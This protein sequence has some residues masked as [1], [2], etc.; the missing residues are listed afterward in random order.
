MSLKH[1]Q[2]H[3]P[4]LYSRF[5]AEG[6]RIR[7]KMAKT[8]SSIWSTWEGCCWWTLSRLTTWSYA[9]SAGPPFLFFFTLVTGPRRSLRL[10]LS[11]STV[12]EPSIRA[13]PPPSSLQPSSGIFGQG[14][15]ESERPPPENGSRH[16]LDLVHLGGLVLV[17]SLDAAADRLWHI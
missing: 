3:P 2:V 1:E 5:Q 11:D 17:A 14:T 8:T 6:V 7:L 4:L 16:I 13:G 10:K 15:F 9:P 12:Y